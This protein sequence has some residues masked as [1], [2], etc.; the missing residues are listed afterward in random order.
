MHL[1]HRFIISC[2]EEGEAW[3]KVVNETKFRTLWGREH[4]FLVAGEN[5]AIIHMSPHYWS[6]AEK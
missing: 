2:N 3:T 6:A 5:R 4:S 1:S